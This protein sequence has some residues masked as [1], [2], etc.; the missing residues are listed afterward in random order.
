MIFCSA[1]SHRAGVEEHSIGFVER[2]TRFVARHTHH[3]GHHFTVGH[4]HLA[5]V[6]FYIEMFHIL[7]W[8]CLKLVVG[9]FWPD[10]FVIGLH[11]HFVGLLAFLAAKAV[12]SL[13]DEGWLV[14]ASG[15]EA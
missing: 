11:E 2:V 12:D 6:C 7:V 4:I 5:A 1:L 14:T 10:N 15:G 9:L 13:V 3:G 8:Y